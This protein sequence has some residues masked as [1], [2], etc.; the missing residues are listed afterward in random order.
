LTHRSFASDGEEH[1][2]HNERLEFLGD[3][4]LGTVVADI[5]YTDYPHLSEGDMTRGRAAVVGMPGLA[6]I[7]RELGIGAHLRLSKGEEATGGREKDSLLADT[8]EALVGALYLDKGMAATSAVVRDLFSDLIETAVAG[9]GGNF[10]GLLQEE[11]VR[12]LAAR[13]RYDVSS[14]GPEHDKRFT[15]RVFVGGDLCG[16][17]SGRSK[18]EAEQIAAAQALDAIDEIA[19]RVAVVP[20]L[21]ASGGTSARAS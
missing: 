1:P 20:N 13:P 6:H 11:V 15:A 3:A 14:S 5:L 4:V 8:L 12:R 10:K 17:G 19:A 7:A 21:D 9:E 18:K 16:E 2:V